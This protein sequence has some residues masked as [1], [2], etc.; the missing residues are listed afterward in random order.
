M[1]CS[2]VALSGK[3]RRSLVL[4]SK[5]LQAL[6]ND[7]EFGE[8]EPYMI[9]MNNFLIKRRKSVQVKRYYMCSAPSSVNELINAI[10]RTS[11]MNCQML[12]RW[13]H[14]WYQQL[15]T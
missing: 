5:V 8:K 15:F 13:G 1:I 14:V 11:L 10:S 7:V 6:A 12:M 4:I 9:V 2:I 3:S